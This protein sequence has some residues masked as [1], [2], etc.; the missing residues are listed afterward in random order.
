MARPPTPEEAPGRRRKKKLAVPGQA[1]GTAPLV[2]PSAEEYAAL[3]K[4]QAA[5]RGHTARKAL[6]AVRAFVA[7]PAPERNTA[8]TKLQAA[9][10]G[11]QARVARGKLQEEARVAWLQFYLA[12]GDV[13]EAEGLWVTAEEA[14]KVEALRVARAS[15]PL[16][17]WLSCFALQPASS[18]GRKTPDAVNNL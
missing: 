4:V 17:G 16:A 8:A 13:E 18:S 3:I 7:L 6:L 1:D 14:A 12:E 11:H 15:A 5:V 10:R 9:V 2:A